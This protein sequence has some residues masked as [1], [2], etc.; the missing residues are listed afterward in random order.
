MKKPEATYKEYQRV[1]GVIASAAQLPE[2]AD[3]SMLMDRTVP[4]LMLF[5][6]MRACKKPSGGKN[7]AYYAEEASAEFGQEIR[8]AP[9]AGFHARG[10][11]RV[12][13]ARRPRRG[14]IIIA[15]RVSIKY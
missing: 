5:I 3:A 4:L 13:G 7:K 9:R 12:V 6:E 14:A 11:R 8:L 15:V 1:R 2:V 10:L